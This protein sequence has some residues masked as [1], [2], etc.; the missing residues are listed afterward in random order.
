MN[1]KEVKEIRMFLGYSQEKLARELGVSFCT[2]NRWERGR[3]NPSPMASEK[4]KELKSQL[5][6]SALTHKRNAIRMNVS[7]E[8]RVEALNNEH[9][10]DHTCPI[11]SA[12]TKN[13][14]LGGLQFCTD[15]P[16]AEGDMIRI[17]LD[18][19]GGE[20]PVEMLSN[21]KWAGESNGSNTVG[22]SFDGVEP[23]D[24]NRIKDAMLMAPTALC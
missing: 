5:E 16:L 21:V 9:S 13:L 18:A 8:I 7:S 3:T 12:L 20:V 11:F 1:P 23:A 15:K 2:V 10:G 22:V 6:S 14:S 4:L 19:P 17:Y 24:L